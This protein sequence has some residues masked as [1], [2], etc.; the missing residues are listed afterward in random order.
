MPGRL[1]T[2]FLAP[3]HPSTRPPQ[4]KTPIVRRP[5]SA[6]SRLP[7]AGCLAALFPDEPLGPQYVCLKGIYCTT[8]IVADV[9]LDQVILYMHNRVMGPV[10]VFVG[11]CLFKK[12]SASVGALLGSRSVAGKLSTSKFRNIVAWL[13][14]GPLAATISALGM[15]HPSMRVCVS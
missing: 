6:R 2:V 9:V 11:N 7:G 1:E 10:V 3:L 4:A 15:A 14:S 5:S 13:K 8:D 12:I